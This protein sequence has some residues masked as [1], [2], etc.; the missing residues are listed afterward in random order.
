MDTT[1][2][3]NNNTW[4]LY[5]TNK[6][7]AEE[8]AALQK[9]VATCELC[10]DIKEGIDTMAKPEELPHTVDALNKKVDESLA[11]KQKRKTIP[12]WYWS[13]AAVLLITLTIGFLYTTNNS[14]GI[15]LTETKK[16]ETKQEINKPK[17][18]SKSNT[19]PKKDSTNKGN[20]SVKTTPKK[21]GAKEKPLLLNTN[22]EFEKKKTE[23]VNKSKTTAPS[24]EE[25]LLE[26][27]MGIEVDTGTLLKRSSVTKTTTTEVTKGSERTKLTLPSPQMNNMFNNRNYNDVN[28]N[29]G[30]FNF[31]QA[32]DSLNYSIALAYYKQDSLKRCTEN[33]SQVI[34]DANSLLYEDALLLQ[35]KIY[36]K[37]LKK[38]EARTLLK[39]VVGIRG[40]HKREAK[41]L[42][43]KLKK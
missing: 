4:E 24:S 25:D 26:K 23:T 9:H 16:E 40:K 11:Y 2:C 30:V 5:A 20:T 17:N 1:H 35:A 22:E 38:E 36:I 10:S 33:L 32:T 42:L 28:S 8:L 43:R 41:K 13:A 15:A 18:A 3:I 6:L 29:L 19:N 14:S 31:K 12:I 37:Q 21:E 27:D 39:K 7:N 34:T